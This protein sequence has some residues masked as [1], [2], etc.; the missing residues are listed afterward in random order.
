MTL[1]ATTGS[2]TVPAHHDVSQT[3]RRSRPVSICP[4]RGLGLSRGSSSSAGGLGLRG[5]A[6]GA[7]HRRGARLPGDLRQHRVQHRLWTVHRPRPADDRSRRS[8]RRHRRWHRLRVGHVPRRPRGRDGPDVRRVGQRDAPLRAHRGR[9][10]RCRRRRHAR[11]PVR[12]A[13]APVRELHAHAAGRRHPGHHH[14]QHAGR[15]QHGAQHPGPRRLPLRC[16]P[17]RQPAG[18][19]VAAWRLHR[20]PARDADHLAPHEDLHRARGRNRDRAELPPP[21][22]DRRRHRH[23]ADGHRG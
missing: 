20:R 6:G 3:P 2:K 10:S 8:R 9:R 13:A 22:P 7:P 15:R 4:G 11:Q 18:R 14:P 21:V 17:A 16:G 12:G 5:P 23:R 19:S 1:C